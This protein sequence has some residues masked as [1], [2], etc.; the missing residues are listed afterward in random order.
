VPRSPGGTGERLGLAWW[1]AVRLDGA[2]GEP[3]AQ[4][5]LGGRSGGRP[6][7]SEEVIRALTDAG[8]TDLAQ[9]RQQAALRTRLALA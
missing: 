8:R 6:V 7:P 1:V 5:G 4:W 2:D 9:E 3:M